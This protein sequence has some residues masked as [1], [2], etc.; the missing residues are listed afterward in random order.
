MAVLVESLTVSKYFG[1]NWNKDALNL[2]RFQLTSRSGQRCR[3]CLTLS[4]EQRQKGVS[5]QGGAFGSDQEIGE[6]LNHWRISYSSP[7]PHGPAKSFLLW[8]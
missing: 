6:V 5:R 8:R 1:S 7:I 2:M 3:L 4:Q